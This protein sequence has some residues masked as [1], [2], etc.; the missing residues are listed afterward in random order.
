[1][2]IKQGV[3]GD[4]AFRSTMYHLLI[5]FASLG[6]HPGNLDA[7]SVRRR[8]G[9][10]LSAKPLDGC[11]IFPMPALH[12]HAPESTNPAGAMLVYQSCQRPGSP[13]NTNRF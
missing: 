13:L 5:L 11:G 8:T 7:A 1:M 6:R 12:T 3:D 10:G 9:P 2:Q 4:V